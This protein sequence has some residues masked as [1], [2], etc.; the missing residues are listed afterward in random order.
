ML[1]DGNLTCSDHLVM[2]LIVESLSCIPE[3]NVVVYINCIPV[4]KNNQHHHPNKILGPY[5]YRI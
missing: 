3:T 4:G 5:V 1:T 2:Y